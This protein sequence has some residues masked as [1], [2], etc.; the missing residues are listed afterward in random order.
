MT[1]GEGYAFEPMVGDQDDHRPDSF[2]SLL[3]DPEAVVFIPAGV[4]H[5]FD[6]PGSTRCR[7]TLSSRPSGSGC[8][9][10]SETPRPARRPTHPPGPPRNDVRTGAVEFDPE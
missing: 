1:I 7:C 4:P 9:I 6:N 10:S 5:G 3:V 8:A 2:W